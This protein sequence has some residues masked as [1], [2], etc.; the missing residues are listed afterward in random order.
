MAT[1]TLRH[2]LVTSDGELPEESLSGYL[3]S[4]GAA[5]WNTGYQVVAIMGPQSSGKS[6]LMNHVFGEVTVIPF[7]PSS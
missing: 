7:S 2:Q 4:L 1:T 3:D 6:T 5:Q